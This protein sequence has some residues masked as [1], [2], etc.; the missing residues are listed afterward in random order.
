MQLSHV[1]VWSHIEDWSLGLSHFYDQYKMTNITFTGVIILLNVCPMLAYSR[2]CYTNDNDYC[3]S[4]II[5][6]IWGNIISN[7]QYA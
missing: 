3:S 6:E 7:S 1:H 2:T 5:Y 4:K